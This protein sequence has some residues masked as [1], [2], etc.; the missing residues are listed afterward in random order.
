MVGQIYKN[1]NQ[2]E[3]SKIMEVTLFDMWFPVGIVHLQPWCFVSEA[4]YTFTL[5]K[6]NSKVSCGLICGIKTDIQSY[7][8]GFISVAWTKWMGWDWGLNKKEKHP[9]MKAAILP[10][11]VGGMG[12]CGTGTNVGEIQRLTVVFL[13][14]TGIWINQRGQAATDMM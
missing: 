1:S 5:H 7:S 10:L 2:T 8:K 6:N 9:L 3:N 4:V 11:S 14:P 13:P 12:L